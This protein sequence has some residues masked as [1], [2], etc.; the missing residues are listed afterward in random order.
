LRLIEL[1]TGRGWERVR[2]DLDQ[3]HRVD[4]RTKDGAFQVVTKLTPEQR[5][6]LKTLEITPPKQV[7]A[8][9]LDA[10]AA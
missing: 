3:I 4:L 2:D 7:Q 9:R 6:S 10:P 1:A 5:K 8:A